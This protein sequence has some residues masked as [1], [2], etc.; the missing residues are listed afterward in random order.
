MALRSDSDATGAPSHRRRPAACG[1]IVGV[2]GRSVAGKHLLHGDRGGSGGR[3]RAHGGHQSLQDGWRLPAPMTA[4]ATGH[5][6]SVL[7]GRPGLPLAQALGQPR[8]VLAL[9]GVQH[10]QGAMHA[11]DGVSGG[12]WSAGTSHSAATS[13]SSPSARIVPGASTMSWSSSM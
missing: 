2:C 13:A 11:G 6:H 7:P 8:R 1:A 9:A 3:K 4:P 12:H 5:A 10:R